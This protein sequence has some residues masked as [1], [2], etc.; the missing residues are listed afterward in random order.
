MLINTNY[1]IVEQFLRFY[2]LQC[3]GHIFYYNIIIP[4][5][6]IIVDFHIIFR[7]NFHK[8]NK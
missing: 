5:C 7:T 4:P 3:Y 1:K 8:N 2:Y 6:M